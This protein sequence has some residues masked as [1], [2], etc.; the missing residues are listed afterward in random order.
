MIIA[1]AVN[2]APIPEGD[3]RFLSAGAISVPAMILSHHCL[4]KDGVS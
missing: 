1:C 2:V 4:R 3:Y